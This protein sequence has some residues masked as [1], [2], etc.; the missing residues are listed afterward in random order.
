MNLHVFGPH[1]H[2]PSRARRRHLKRRV[3]PSTGVSTG[4]VVNRPSKFARCAGR[5]NLEQGW[6]GGSNAPSTKASKSTLP[7]N[8]S[9]LIHQHHSTRRA[10]ASDAFGATPRR[11][12]PLR[13][14]LTV[15]ASEVRFRILSNSFRRSGCTTPAILLTVHNNT[16]P[17]PTSRRP[18]R[19]PTAFALSTSGAMYSGVPQT[20]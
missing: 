4:S 8:A 2:S 10:A 18:C 7:K 20:L 12:R 1:E 13:E 6:M 17:D 9:P 19:S 14:G 11:R 16:R 15:A 3:G 5:D